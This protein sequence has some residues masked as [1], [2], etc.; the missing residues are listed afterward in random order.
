MDQNATPEPR[1]AGPVSA[2]DAAGT[3]PAGPP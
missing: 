1:P 3:A 2:P